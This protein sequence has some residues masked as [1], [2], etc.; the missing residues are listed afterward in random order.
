MGGARRGGWSGGLFVRVGGW[1]VHGG[2][3]VALFRV[4]PV[5]DSV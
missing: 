5:R 4:V 3:K 1:L 2:A